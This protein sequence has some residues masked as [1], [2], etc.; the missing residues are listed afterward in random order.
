MEDKSEKVISYRDEREVI[1]KE[2]NK[3]EQHATLTA[4]I[5]HIGGAIGGWKSMGVQHLHETRPDGSISDEA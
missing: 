1:K 5:S 3:R 4:R 2:E